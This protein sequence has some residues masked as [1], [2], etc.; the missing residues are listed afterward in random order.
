MI[1]VPGTNAVVDG[2]LRDREH[3]Y[4]IQQGNLIQLKHYHKVPE[5]MPTV[6]RG[7]VRDFTPAARLRMLKM[8]ARMDW[9]KI[10]DSQFVTLTYPD[11]N[12]EA[13]YQGRTQQRSQFIRWAESEMGKP[14]PMLWRI[15]WKAR[16]SGERIGEV[17]P[18]IHFVM[19]GADGIDPVGV[20]KTWTKIIGANQFVQ[21]DVETCDRSKAPAMYVAKY[22]AKASSPLLDN[23]AYLNNSTGRHWG[24]TRKNMIPFHPERRS[25]KLGTDQ[26]EMMR[27]IAAHHLRDRPMGTFTVF[28]DDA[29]VMFDEI[30][31]DPGKE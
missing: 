13:P 5:K 18:H 6:R 11:A 15:E 29:G 3:D 27:D 17:A 30:A 14:T 31:G 10:A 1:V 28:S 23:G 7:E 8:L 4:L 12:W 22:A 9:G 21:T 20:N 25:E 24:V 19:L 26:V 2:A 16:K